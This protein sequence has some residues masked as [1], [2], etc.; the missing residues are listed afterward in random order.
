MKR[1]GRI[2]LFLMAPSCERVSSS[3]NKLES[4]ITMVALSDAEELE[5]MMKLIDKTNN[6]IEVDICPNTTERIIVCHMR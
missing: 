6:K 3:T 5:Q 2:A 1:N 4:I